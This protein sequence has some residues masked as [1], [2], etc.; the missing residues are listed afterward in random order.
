M[1]L[2][3]KGSNFAGDCWLKFTEAPHIPELNMQGKLSA[4]MRERHAEAPEIVQWVSGVLLLPGLVMSN[5]TWGP[6]SQW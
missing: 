3:T 5:G 2:I 1:I 4:S 6:R